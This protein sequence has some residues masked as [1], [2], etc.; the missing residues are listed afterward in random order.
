[1]TLIHNNNNKTTTTVTFVKVYLTVITV[2]LRSLGDS[3]KTKNNT[4]PSSGV[5]NSAMDATSTSRLNLMHTPNYQAKPTVSEVHSNQV[6]R[7]ILTQVMVVTAIVSLII[8]SSANRSFAEERTRPNILWI[9]AE[10]TSPWMGCY[11]DRVN[12]TG[13]PNIDSIADRG[14]RFSRAFVPAPVC[15]ACR[16][17]LMAGQNQIRINAHEH[18][19]SRGPVAINLPEHTR[20]LPQLMKDSG[21]FT[22]NAGKTDYNFAWDEGATY[23]LLQSSRKDVPWST[24]KQNQPFFGQIQTAGGKNNTKSFPKSRRTDPASVTVPADYP[25]NQLYREVV[26]QHYDAIRKDDDFIGDVLQQLKENGLIEN[27]IVVYFS[28]HGAN[29]LVRHKQMPTEGGLHVPFVL[30]GPDPYIPAPSVRDDLVNLLDLSAT[31]LH[32]GGVEIPQWHEGQNLFAEKLIPRSEVY[33]AKDRLDHTIDRVRSV[34]SDR[35][36]Y[37]KNFKT[38]RI[39]LQPQYRDPKDYVINLRELY[40]NNQLTPLLKKIYFG[41]RPEEEFYDVVAD[42][43]QINNLIDNP[44]FQK[45]VNHHRQLLSDWLAKGDFGSNE[46]P[47]EELAYQANGHKWGEGVNPEYELVRTDGDGDGLSDDWERINGRDPSDSKLIFLFDCGGWQTEGWVGEPK[48][49]NLAGYLGFLDFILP[50]GTGVIRRDRLNITP[51]HYPEHLTIQARVSNM[52]D[53]TL[54]AKFEHSDEH[55][56]IASTRIMP[57]DAFKSISIRPLI[58]AHSWGAITELQIRFLADGE[59]QVELDS[60]MGN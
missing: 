28:D 53:L 5:G 34:R 25:Q 42:P 23:S 10:D 33:A 16:S 48:L 50:D 37:T 31:T 54:V 14:V 1:M 15:S 60:L 32:W 52:T 18:R 43:S 21:Y 11:G 12:E 2:R 36:R 44:E 9:F 7:Q 6:T 30:M 13:T 20:L 27:T 38:D 39:L 41:E 55:H 17:A 40:A 58:T 57:A 56:V 22:F 8:T 46:E 26:A 19:S 45:E 51:E 4:Y 24:I 47:I 29:N 49:G 3:A 59:T 35:F